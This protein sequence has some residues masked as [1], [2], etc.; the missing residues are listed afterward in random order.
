M[1]TQTILNEYYANNAHKLR[2]MVNKILLKFGGISDKDMDD[3]YSLAN[4]VFVD[5]LRRYDGKQSFDGFLHKCLS[6][7]IKTEFT[8]RNRIKRQADRMSVSWDTPIDED[9]G[10]LQDV[11]P[12][13]SI[14]IEEDIINESEDEYS[15]KMLRYLDRLSDLQREVLKLSSYGFTP[16]EIKN[17]LHI[18]AKQYSDCNATIHSYR[19]VAVLF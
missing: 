19:N 1:N 3:F 9:G 17:K 6:N 14:N 10:V 2:Q 5:A 11:I 15:D 18:T 7:K 13:A 4:E 16:D 12:D 8:R